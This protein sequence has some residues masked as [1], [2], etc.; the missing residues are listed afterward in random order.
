MGEYEKSIEDLK[1]S[2]GCLPEDSQILYKCGLTYYA[3]AKYK[4]CIT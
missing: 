4:K 3:D 1:I 2:A